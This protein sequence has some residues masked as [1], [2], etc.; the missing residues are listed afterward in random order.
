MS[1]RIIKLNEAIKSG[2]IYKDKW[3]R[4]KYDN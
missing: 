2:K 3:D 1:E 4:E